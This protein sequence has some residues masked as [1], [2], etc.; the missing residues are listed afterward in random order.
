MTRS[1]IFLSFFIIPPLR[2]LPAFSENFVAYIQDLDEATA[3]LDMAGVSEEERE[4]IFDDMFRS[5][6]AEFGTH[7]VDS[8]EMG[9]RLMTR[10]LFSEEET[11]ATDR[12]D[13]EDCA[14]EELGENTR[15]GGGSSG[16]SAASPPRRQTAV[17][18]ICRQPTL[19]SSIDSSRSFQRTTTISYGASLARDAYS[20]SDAGISSPMPV[21]LKLK[22]IT[23][24]FSSRFMGS[25]S[26]VTSKDG[27]RPI[28]FRRILAWFL[29]RYNDICRSVQ[30]ERS[31][32]LRASRHVPPCCFTI[33]LGLLH[34]E[35]DDSGGCGQVSGCAFGHS[36]K[37]ATEACVDDQDAPDGYRCQFKGC[38]ADERVCPLGEM[39]ARPK[40]DA[41][42]GFVASSHVC[43]ESCS[44]D[45]DVVCR[46]HVERCMPSNRDSRGYTCRS[47]TMFKMEKTVLVYRYIL[48]TF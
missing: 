31:V 25:A 19:D 7:F 34:S 44:S 12:S 29:P 13:R 2:V 35:G 14:R 20:W 23:L 5:F 3:M 1:F 43:V 11:R 32:L 39:C 17:S 9:G 6:I 26:Q 37:E 27:V 33:R 45:E 40:G 41:A 47:V 36:C 4:D 28:N 38:P 48:S 15:K 21:S 22:P 46:P 8:V 30:N 42:S 24:L 10:K 18:D 16:P